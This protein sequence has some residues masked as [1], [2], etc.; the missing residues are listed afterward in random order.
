MKRED[1]YQKLNEIF[2]SVFDDDSIILN[3]NMTS[4]DIEDWDSL[5]NINLVVAIE[6]D[7]K[8]HFEIIFH[9]SSK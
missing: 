5:E 6:K 9:D 2:R 8:I 3:D 7:F 4:D 1:V